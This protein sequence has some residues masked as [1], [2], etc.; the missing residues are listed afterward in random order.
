MNRSRSRGRALVVLSVANLAGIVVLWF[1]GSFVAERW[2]PCAILTY[3]PQLPFGAPLVLLLALSLWRRNRPAVIVN[4]LA[5]LF[6]LLGPMG[7]QLRMPVRTPGSPVLRVMT[8]NI[9]GG[10]RGLSGALR[11]VRQAQPDVVC[12]QEAGLNSEAATRRLEHAIRAG[13]PGYVG[14]RAES[15]MTLTRLPIVRVQSRRLLPG[16][17]SR[18]LLRVTVDF[19]GRLL[20]VANVHF[21]LSTPI[22]H[23]RTLGVRGFVDTATEIRKAQTD[24]LLE[25]MANETRPHIVCGDLNTPPRGMVYGSLARR[26]QDTFAAAGM[27][28]GYTFASRAP[29]LRIDYV[30][31]S[32]GL[33]PVRVLVPPSRASDH[34]PVVADVVLR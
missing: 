23:I 2:W 21:V 34:R 31:L 11:A 16:R 14:R 27:G 19:R 10:T 13:L 1:L 22:T 20:T 5:G 18:P 15:V 30:W 8:Y 32:P 7:F 33:R 25:A 28:F 24:A 12:L 3:L 17:R 26:W 6:F 9:R 4:A 29:L